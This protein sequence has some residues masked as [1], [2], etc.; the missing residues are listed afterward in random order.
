MKIG[1]IGL[2]RMGTN[3]VRRLLRQGHDCVVYDVQKEAVQR[4]VQD[5]AIQASSLQDL[6]EKLPRPRA[7][8]MMVPA[9]VVDSTLETLVP[10]LDSDDITIDGGNSHYHDDIRRSAE[11]KTHGIHYLDVGTS[12]G[13]WGLERGY[14]LMIGGDKTAVR[15]LEPIFV[16][17]APGIESA[18][19]TPGRH[20]HDSTAELGYLH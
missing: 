19:R 11:L 12:G 3:M 17:L 14:C 6:T 7:I 4:L 10:L 16:A 18:P 20:E 1:M 8:W 15:R 5:G 9:A 2:G 13:V